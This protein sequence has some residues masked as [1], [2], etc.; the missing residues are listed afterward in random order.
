[1]KPLV[2]EALI[3]TKDLGQV[4]FLGAIAR[5]FHT[6]VYRES[7]DLDF[8]VKKPISKQELNDKGY[9]QFERNGKLEWFTPRHVKIDIY[10]R[11]VSEIPVK[12]I[13][14]T[15]KE[16]A[17]GKNKDTVLVMSLESLIVA[18][19]RAQRAGDVEDLQ[20]IARAKFQEIRWDLLR[21]LAKNSHEFDS[22]KS[23]VRYLSR[24]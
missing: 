24:L 1:L 5:Y 15:C 14:K 13:I 3:I 8:A 4:V 23:D 6:R 22:I 17:V 2:R 9:N 21:N 20:N 11:D 12:T 10:T 18:K 7:K 16:F 19:H